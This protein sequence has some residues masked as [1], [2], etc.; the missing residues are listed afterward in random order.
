[1]AQLRKTF[2]AVALLVVTSL[3]L[4]CQGPGGTATSP[5]SPPPVGSLV[6]TITQ[7]GVAPKA[8]IVAR[9][10]QV[11]FVNEDGRPHQMASDPHPEHV[12]CPEINSVGYLN[13]GQSRQTGNLNDPVTCGFH[14]HLN[15]SNSTLHG[16]ITIE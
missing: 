9:G 3:T 14:D 4:G 12:E 2:A 7:A 6:V 13:Q 10:S 5:T 11:T 8:V 1:M 15:G 16:T